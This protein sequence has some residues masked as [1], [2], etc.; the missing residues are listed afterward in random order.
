MSD[1]LLAGETQIVLKIP[2]A[3]VFF[4]DIHNWTAKANNISSEELVKYLGY[5]YRVMDRVGDSLGVYKVKTIGDAYLGIAGLPGSARQSLNPCLD[6]LRFA[7]YVAQIFSNRFIHPE[8]GAILKTVAQKRQV[9]TWFSWT[10]PPPP[11]LHASTSDC[12]RLEGNRRPL[13]T[14]GYPPTAV[15]C[16]PT[17]V[18]YPPTAVGYPPTAVGY[19]P[20]AVGHF[21]AAV[22]PSRTAIG[23]PSSAGPSCA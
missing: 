21:F 20:T 23:C 4:S 6:M 15:G 19:P 13:E 22:D 8:A 14:V 5:T 12:R 7:S 11:L 1:L 2:H 9:R 3:A 16:P 10:T 17:A 18:G